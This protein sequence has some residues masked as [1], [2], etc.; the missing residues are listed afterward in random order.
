VTKLH[1]H[2]PKKKTVHGIAC[3]AADKPLHVVIAS[4]LPQEVSTIE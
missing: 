1:L 2:L 3:T 4:M